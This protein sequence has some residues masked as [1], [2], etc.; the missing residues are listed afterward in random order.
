M[1]AGVVSLDLLTEAEIKRID[2]LGHALQ[3]GLRDAVAAMGF[4]AEVRRAGSILHIDSPLMT[5]IHKSALE[6]GVFIAPRGQMSIS[7]PMT[8]DVISQSMDR[9]E[10]ALRAARAQP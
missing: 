3:T 7:T 4:P 8:E 9:L 5:S 1:E 2:D 10:E 6:Q